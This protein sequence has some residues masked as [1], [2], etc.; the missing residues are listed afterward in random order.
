MAMSVEASIPHA[1]PSEEPG[2]DG[3]VEAGEHRVRA[4]RLREPP[5]H[6]RRRRQ[7]PEAIPIVR[8]V[9]RGPGGGRERVREVD[10]KQDPVDVVGGRRRR[11]GG[12]GGRVRAWAAV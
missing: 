12:G 2:A 9:V 5:V 3:L 7:R 4:R 10:R 6:P 8:V 11:G 1:G